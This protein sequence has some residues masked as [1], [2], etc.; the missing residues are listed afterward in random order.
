MS[1]LFK[2]AGSLLFPCA[3]EALP[4]ALLT[5]APELAI[6]AAPPKAPALEAAASMDTAPSSLATTATLQTVASIMGDLRM[7]PFSDSDE[8]PLILAQPPAKRPFSIPAPRTSARVAAK[9]ALAAHSS[10]DSGTAGVAATIPPPTSARA[11]GHARKPAHPQRSPPD[12]P[13]LLLK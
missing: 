7:S 5:V 8:E 3:D 11:P 13:L 4:S 2:A 10:G 9:A 1:S 12:T 6:M